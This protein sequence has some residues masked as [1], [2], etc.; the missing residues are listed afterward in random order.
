MATI[1]TVPR[2][3]EPLTTV[4]VEINIPIVVESN[5]VD[6]IRK[7]ERADHREWCEACDNLDKI[8]KQTIAE[9][10]EIIKADATIFRVSEVDENGDDDLLYE[11]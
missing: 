2:I 4:F 6:E 11:L 7:L 1:T 3:T 8:I 10:P 5:L 9:N